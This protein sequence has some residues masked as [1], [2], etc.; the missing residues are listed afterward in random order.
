MFRR[1]KEQR[2]EGAVET[3]DQFAL[4]AGRMYWLALVL[5]DDE[6]LAGSLTHDNIEQLVTGNAVFVHWIG[7]WSRRIIIKACIA[8]KQADLAVDQR[9]TASWDAATADIEIV[10]AQLLREF[11][12]DSIQR[13]ARS[14]PLLPRFL[15]VMNVLEGYSL[16]DAAQLLQIPRNICEAALRYA[17]AALTDAIHSPQ[18][19]SRVESH[20]FS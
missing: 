11:S 20:S 19:C 18:L 9:N 4:A 7:R 1:N 10:N 5:T 17:F 3:P 8:A 13:S 12:I 16:Y 15:F 6:K 14:L 2:H